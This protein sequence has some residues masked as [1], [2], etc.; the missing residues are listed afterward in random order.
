MNESL[1]PT[2]RG[3]HLAPCP[4]APNNLT[5]PL[6]GR[7]LEKPGRP[8][9]A[10]VEPKVLERIRVPCRHACHGNARKRA[11]APLPAKDHPHRAESSRPRSSTENLAAQAPYLHR[12]ALSPRRCSPRGRTTHR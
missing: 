12:G 5:G 9:E 7:W 10:L 1:Q 6:T 8:D 3:H 4:V 11:R 2:G